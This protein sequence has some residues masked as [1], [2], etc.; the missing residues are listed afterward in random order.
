MLRCGGCTAVRRRPDGGLLA[1]LW[2][3]PNVAGSCTE[4]EALLQAA[5]WGTGEVLLQRRKGADPCFYTCRVA[6][7]LL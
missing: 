3:L 6:Y 7:D 4:E 1:G 5:A 2:E